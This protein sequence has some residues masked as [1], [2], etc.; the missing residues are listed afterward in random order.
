MTSIFKGLRAP[1]AVLASLPFALIGS[2]MFLLIFR[3]SWTIGS[4]VGLV[5]LVGIVA[6]NGRDCFGR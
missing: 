3:Q 5:M 1:L 4:L 6:T 2:V